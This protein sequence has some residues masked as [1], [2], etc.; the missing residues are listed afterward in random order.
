MAKCFPSLNAQH[1]Q[2]IA[3]QHLFFVATAT[4]ESR[5]NLSPKG[6]NTLKVLGPDRVVWLN[7]TGSGNESA[8]HVQADPRMTLMF[9]AFTGT[10]L[11]LRVYGKARVVHPY[12]ADWAEWLAHFPAQVGA[13]QVFVL[14]VDL[15][16]TSCGFGVP[17]MAYEGD[18][19]QLAKWAEAKGDDG[20][21][22]YWRERNQHSIDGI[23]THIQKP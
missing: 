18:R 1:Q 15:V 12:D 8:A 7:L 22:Q 2:F 21:H 10:P 20:L 11:I 3:E 16:Q 6:M 4:A 19:E 13:R 17:L 14:T 9:C 5:V 23:A